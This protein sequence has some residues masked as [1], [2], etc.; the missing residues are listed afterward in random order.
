LVI[1]WI[2]FQYRWNVFRKNAPLSDRLRPR[3]IEDFVGQ[4][5]IIGEG[6]FLTRAIKADRISSMIFYGP[7]GTGKTT[8]AMVIA[9]STK[10]NFEKISAVTSG[11]KEIRE[12]INK[13]EE[14][15]KSS[16]K[17]TILF[18]D[19]IHR[20]NKAQQD[21]LLPFVEK[22]IIILIGATTENPYFEIN[23]ALLSRMMV[24]ELKPLSRDEL[25][26]LL[27]RALHDKE[28]GLGNLNIDIA[29]D[30][31]DYLLT[32][33]DGDAR[34]LL[35]SLEIGALSTE[36]LAD[37]IRHISL[38]DIKNSIQIKSFKYDKGSDEHYDT[39][40]AFIKSMRGSDPD[41]AV[42][43]LAKMLNAG[44]DPKFIARRI[45]IAASEDVGNADPNAIVIATN[46]FYAVNAIGMPE[47]RII[48]SQATI[49]VACA[50]KS[51]SSYLAINSALEDI[52]K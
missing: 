28:Y 38:D 13:A 4:E 11:V 18:I 15:L 45:M 23:K 29:D 27:D 35:N 8:L 36:P 52:K 24:I 6:K 26:V 43:Y 5:H 47:A 16:N 40:S 51:N 41:A 21:A 48:L 49:Y 2:Y 42:F 37:G 44:E 12:V 34:V 22:G 17:R 14:S 19:E 7:P 10:M 9:N 39:I 46:A 30:A 50:P 31:I 20:F 3:K 1:L 25:N 33:A 32:V